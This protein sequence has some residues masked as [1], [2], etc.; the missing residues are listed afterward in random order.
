M[1]LRRA[2]DM[3]R[4]CRPMWESPISPSSSAL[5]TR[6]AT[7]STTSTSMAPDRTRASVISRACSPRVGLGNEQVVDVDAEF[8]GVAGIEGVLGVNECSQ[9]AGAL[10]LGDDLEGDCGFARG[11]WAEDLRDPAAGDA[12]NSQRR[13]ETDGA[14]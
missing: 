6:A 9:A 13:V 12:A 3:R 7:E 4:A 5:G 2:W 14:G 8:L 1:S 10:R 11:F